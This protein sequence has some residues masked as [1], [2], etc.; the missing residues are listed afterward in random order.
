MPLFFYWKWLQTGSVCIHSL[1]PLNSTCVSIALSHEFRLNCRT[2]LPS[3]MC[4]L[5]WLGFML[6]NMTSITA[7]PSRCLPL[8]RSEKSSRCAGFAYFHCGFH[9]LLGCKKFLSLEQD[10]GRVMI[11]PLCNFCVCKNES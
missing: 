3:V 8:V 2:G 5:S 7:V 9:I 11:S 10:L 4:S 6:M 1:T